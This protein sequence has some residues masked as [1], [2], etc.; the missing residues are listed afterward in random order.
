MVTWVPCAGATLHLPSG[1]LNGSG[2]HLFIVL[3]DP[4]TFDNYGSA[5]CIALV[6]LSS[7]PVEGIKFDSTCILTA[8]CHPS[9]RQDSYVYYKGTR[10]DQVRDVQQRLGMGIYTPGE[11]INAQMLLQIK[12]GLLQS[13]FT[14]R[15]FKLLGI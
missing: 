4:K 12:T 5:V 7:V 8:G 11:A 6:N 9:V 13:P 14:K 1:P 10:I 2:K 15:E 3:N